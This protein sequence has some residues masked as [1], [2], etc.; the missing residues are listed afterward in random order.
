MLIGDRIKLSAADTNNSEFICELLNDQESTT[1]QNKG[2]IPITIPEEIEYIT[3]C[4]K[5]NKDILFHIYKDYTIIG[6][7]GLHKI[8]W[9]HRSAMIGIVIVK[10]CRNKGYATEACKLIKD[11]GLDTLNMH[12]IWAEVFAKNKAMHKVFDKLDFDCSSK[13]V[14]VYFKHGRYYDINIRNY[15]KG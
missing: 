8:D 4:Q 14:D 3:N 9:I 1:Y 11:Y 5:S 13:I 12:R 2:I 7:I 6:S 10:E 15:T